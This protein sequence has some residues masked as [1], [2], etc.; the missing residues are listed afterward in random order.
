MIQHTRQNSVRLVLLC[1]AA[2]VGLA[3]L[4]CTTTC[5]SGAICGDYNSVG[6]SV[7]TPTPT[8]A[9]GST[10]DPCRVEGVTVSF[11]SGAQMPFLALGEAH[12]I[13]ATPVNASGEVPKGCNVAREPIWQV[14]TPTTCQ[15]IGS[16]YNPFVRGLRVGTCSI[17][18]TVSSVISAPFSVEVR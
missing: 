1:L 13:D 8:P 18:A 15:V 4:G 3:A 16:G 2:L 5:E 9:P 14:L 12:Q 10:P 7:P 11:H 17:T 6:P